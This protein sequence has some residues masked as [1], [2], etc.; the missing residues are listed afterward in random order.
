MPNPPDVENPDDYRG[1]GTAYLTYCCDAWGRVT[2]W[3]GYWGAPDAPRG[4]V[5]DAGEHATADAA[6][7]WARERTDRV[8]LHLLD[9]RRYWAG[10]AP[11]PPELPYTFEPGDPEDGTQNRRLWAES[12]YPGDVIT[13]YCGPNGDDTPSYFYATCRACNWQ[14][15]HLTTLAEA[16][17]ALAQH[18]GVSA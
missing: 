6:V 15:E 9:G 14:S 5:Q 7:A 1:T 8:V 17:A 16:E 12:H 3:G 11:P 18:R 4:W 2:H 10:M 13:V